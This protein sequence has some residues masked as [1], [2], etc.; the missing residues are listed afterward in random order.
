MTQQERAALIS[1][2][3]TSAGQIF[4]AIEATNALNAGPEPTPE[5][6]AAV[7]S[8]LKN[9]LADSAAKE[10]AIIAARQA[11]GL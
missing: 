5:Q 9:V 6:L 3:L 7:E 11:A 4:A 8:A 10:A 1:A 2:L